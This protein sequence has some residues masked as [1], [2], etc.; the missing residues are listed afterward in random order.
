MTTLHYEDRDSHFAGSQF[1]GKTKH[2]GKPDKRFRQQKFTKSFTG[3]I[4]Y[5][6]SGTHS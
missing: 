4:P 1:P 2:T 6:L 3:F 5:G